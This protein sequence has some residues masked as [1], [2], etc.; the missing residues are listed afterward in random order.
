MGLNKAATL[1]GVFGKI[2][3]RGMRKEGGRRE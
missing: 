1:M 3:G 2:G